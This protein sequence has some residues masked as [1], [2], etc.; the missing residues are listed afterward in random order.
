MKI[1]VNG[2]PHEVKATT[3]AAILTEIGYGEAMVATALNGDFVSADRRLS[4]TVRE[5][6]ALEVLA[7]RQGG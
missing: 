4:Q 7:P 1:S 5:G 3:I 2:Q 6:D